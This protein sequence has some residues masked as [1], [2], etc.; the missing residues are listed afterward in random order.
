MT[1][2]ALQ[3]NYRIISSR[4]QKSPW[5]TSEFPS[6]SHENSDADVFVSEESNAEFS[7]VADVSN[8]Y[9]IIENIQFSSGLW[10]NVNI[11][12]TNYP[13]MHCHKAI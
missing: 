10:I 6:K 9:I 12:E 13:N 1:E 11:V 7:T 8:T 5:L 4:L 3:T 2:Y